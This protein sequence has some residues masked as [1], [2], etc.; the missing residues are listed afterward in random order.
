M[1]EVC[2]GDTSMYTAH[3][4]RNSSALLLLTNRIPVRQIKPHLDFPTQV[5]APPPPAFYHT[6]LGVHICFVLPS[7]LSP[8]HHLSLA[9]LQSELSGPSVRK[10]DRVIWGCV[11]PGWVLMLLHSAFTFPEVPSPVQFFPVE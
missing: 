3:C 7:S 5:C 8:T 6:S 1:G 2:E 11:F 9:G 4:S 10:Q